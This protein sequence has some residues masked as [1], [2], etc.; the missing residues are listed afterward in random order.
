MPRFFR[1]LSEGV[2]DEDALVFRTHELARFIEAATIAYELDSKRII[3]VGYS[4]GANIADSLLLLEP[5]VLSAA[6]LFRSMVA[7]ESKQLPDPTGKPVLML[8][9]RQDPIVLAGISERLAQLLQ[10]AG[11]EVR[12]HWQ[13]GGHGLTNPELQIA[14]EWVRGLS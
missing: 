10:R 2:F 1:R 3:A 6:V 13:N 12:L 9:G 11:A 5:S 7:L 14:G 8:S 4:N